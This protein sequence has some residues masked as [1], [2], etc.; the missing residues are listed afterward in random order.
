MANIT[1]DY[2][3]VIRILLYNSHDYL[4]NLGYHE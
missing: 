2:N 1:L 4:N 3:N